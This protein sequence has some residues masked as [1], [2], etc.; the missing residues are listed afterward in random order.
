[1]AR[2]AHIRSAN[3]RQALA[4]GDRAIMTTDAII[5]DGAVIHHCP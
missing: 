5:G 4:A 1:M 2:F 3:M